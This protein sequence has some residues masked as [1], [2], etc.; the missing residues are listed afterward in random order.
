MTVVSRFQDHAVSTRLLI[1]AFLLLPVTHTSAQNTAVLGLPFKILYNAE[2]RGIFSNPEKLDV[3]YVFNF[4][5]SRQGTRLALWENVLQP[6]T[7]RV[8]RRAMTRTPLGWEADIPLD[9]TAALVSWYITD[10]VKRDDND[11][12]TFVTYVKDRQGE[13]VR[14]A[15]YF[16]T[17]FLELARA[18][19]SERAREAEAEISFH[20]LNLRAYPLFFTLI[21]ARDK[22]SDV[23]QRRIVTMLED[24]ERKFPESPDVL[25]LIAR[26]YY[27]IFRDEKRGLEYKDRIDAREQWDEVKMM[28]DREQLLEDNRR[29]ALE[30]ENRRKALMNAAMPDFRFP[31]GDK[32]SYTVSQD[33]GRAVVL[34]FWISSSEQSRKLLLSLKDVPATFPKGSVHFVAISLD[35]K[36][37]AAQAVFTRQGIP[38]DLYMNHPDAVEQLGIDGI[39]YTLVIDKRGIIRTIFLGTSPTL[40]EDI[41]RAVKAVQ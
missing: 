6:D 1:L 8:R 31:F 39:P 26:T 22:G 13:P 38:F 34:M 12:K 41:E 40:T 25:S 5:N 30:N 27:Y 33:R 16:M 14:N 29:M 37:E 15:R 4:W 10:G 2:T 18:D 9:S 20:P 23:T 11:R 28:V 7:A 35:E 17:S 36:P 19:I 21:M 24:L 3:V 32:A